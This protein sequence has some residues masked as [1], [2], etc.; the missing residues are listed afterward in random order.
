MK[1]YSKYKDSGILWIGKMP[2]HW[3]TIRFRFLC[4]IGTGDMKVKP[5]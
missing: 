1:V 5:F 4:K 2:E 3:K